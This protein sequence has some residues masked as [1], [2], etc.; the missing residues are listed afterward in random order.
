MDMDFFTSQ[1]KQAEVKP[2]PFGPYRS[3]LLLF[4]SYRYEDCSSSL[5]CTYVFLFIC[6]S[7]PSGFQSSFKPRRVQKDKT[8][9]RNLTIT[10]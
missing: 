9:V 2:F 6:S 5:T 7:V 8:L 3:P 4:K 1:S 10:K